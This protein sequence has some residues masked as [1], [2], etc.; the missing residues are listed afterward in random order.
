M[1]DGAAIAR[2]SLGL[3]DD[4]ARALAQHAAW[5]ALARGESLGPGRC[6]VVVAGSVATGDGARVL[7]R[8]G[9]F[10]GD[11][12]ALRDTTL[13]VFTEA[14]LEATPRAAIAFG[15]AAA[16]PIAER[17]RRVVAVC[18][19]ARH[20]N[21]ARSLREALEA[22]GA[23][24]S[25]DGS[26]WAANESHSAARLA[27]WLDA[28]DDRFVLLGCSDEPGPWER[29]AFACADEVLVLADAAD[30]PGLTA[31][32]RALCPAHGQ[33]WTLALVHPRDA[34]M[35]RGTAR[36]LDARSGS[37]RHR[38]V[39]EGCVDDV[40]RLARALAGTE[41]AVVLGAGGARGFAHLGVLRALDEV[42]VRP[43]HLAGT[44]VGALV[45]GALA[46]G[47]S[48]DEVAALGRVLRAARP[49]GD[50]TLP[51]TSL[52]R[53]ARLE[54]AVREALGD[55][56]IEDLWRPFFCNACDIAGLRD[57]ALDRGSLAEA[58]L[59]SC[60]LPGMFAPRR[61]G[62]ALLIDGG[63]TDLLPVSAMRARSEGTLVAV[64]VSR[65]RAI[66]P[67]A[68][69]RGWWWRFLAGDARALSASEVFWRAA[70]LDPARRVEDAARRADLFLRPPVEGFEMDDLRAMEEITRVGYEYARKALAGRAA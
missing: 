23:T 56:A 14:A 63:T 17:G 52:L 16:S 36:W 28:R 48:L 37:V 70:T 1:I 57:V 30:D 25:V 3:D 61:I 40:A 13:M 34:A 54:R 39:R 38:H 24:L 11:A 67:S 22:Q 9:V 21:L 62:D 6:G 29:S 32:E 27:G 12:L 65:T 43:D 5:Q 44:S 60:A 19:M 58:C 7:G 47:R 35:P 66:D 2:A 59:A 51:V 45:G 33:R 68:A 55:V 50:W 53:G 10:W 64:D 4:V 8:G 15:R 26:P 42:G 41:V 46:A 20:R 49:F 31:V 69:R 18:G